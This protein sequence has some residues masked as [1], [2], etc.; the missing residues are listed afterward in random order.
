[1]LVGVLMIVVSPKFVPCL[2]LLQCDTD[3]SCDGDAKL[4]NF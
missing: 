2:G 1:M 4:F 3:D